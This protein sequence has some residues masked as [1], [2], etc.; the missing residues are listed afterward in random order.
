MRGIKKTI[1]INFKGAIIAE[2]TI[3]AILITVPLFLFMSRYIIPAVVEYFEL[4]QSWAKC[5]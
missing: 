2:Y 5:Y 1:K 4:I 3:A